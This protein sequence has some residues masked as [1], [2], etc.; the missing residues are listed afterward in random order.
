MPC[1][2]VIGD[3][4]KVIEP[5]MSDEVLPLFANATV[6]RHPGG[7]FI[8]ATSAQKK[9]YNEFLDQVRTQMADG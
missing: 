2:I 1:L 4:D 6:V 9:V 8:P 5:E 3:T 7:H